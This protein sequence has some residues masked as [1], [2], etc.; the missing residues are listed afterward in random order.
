MVE[1]VNDWKTI[2]AYAGYKQG[3][4]QIIENQKVTEIRVNVGRL[5]FKKKF[6]NKEDPDLKEILEF[7]T[8]KKFI[9]I[10]SNI[11]DQF[12]FEHIPQQ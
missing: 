1:T 3:F 9:E 7:C 12:F 10:S 8:S 5:G 11:M 2:E 4:Y 6:Q